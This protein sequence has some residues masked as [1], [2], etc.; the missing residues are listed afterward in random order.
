MPLG[1]M[2]RANT[3]WREQGELSVWPENGL[4]TRWGDWLGVCVAGVWCW[5]EF[6]GA[7]L[8][9]VNCLLVTKAYLSF[10]AVSPRCG[11]E[12]EEGMVRRESYE[13]SNFKTESDPSLWAPEDRKKSNRICAIRLGHFFQ[14]ERIPFLRV[15]RLLWAVAGWIM[16]EI[17]EKQ[18]KEKGKWGIF[19]VLW[20]SGKPLP[21]LMSEFIWRSLSLPF[22]SLP[23][24]L[25]VWGCLETRPG[26]ISGKKCQVH[27]PF[28]GSSNWVFSLVNQ[29]CLLFMVNTCS[30]YSVQVL[31]LHSVGDTR[32][33]TPSY[34]ELESI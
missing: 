19:S 34:I 4:G 14:S 18:R 20:M 5:G 27:H 7:E 31:Q 32:L 6:L 12:R 23:R 33:P 29:Y 24:L 28:S 3:F 9:S 25:Q 15:F 10:L 30:M 16:W 2:K 26:H 1:G 13:R 8:H 11:A 22:A 17:K 21:F